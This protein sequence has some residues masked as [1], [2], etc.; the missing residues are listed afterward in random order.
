MA[1]LTPWKPMRELETLSRRMDDMF[2]RLPREFKEEL[3][4]NGKAGRP[5]RMRRNRAGSYCIFSNN[6]FRS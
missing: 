1:A 5:C 3:P 2:N 4:A 6:S